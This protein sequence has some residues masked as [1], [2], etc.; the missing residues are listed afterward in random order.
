MW[1]DWI[2]SMYKLKRLSAGSGLPLRFT[3]F[4]VWYCKSYVQYWTYWYWTPT[5]GSVLVAI[6][7]MSV[8]QSLQSKPS[9]YVLCVG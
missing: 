6:T 7:D 2:Y 3:V 4:T 5:P 8:L 1:P 9:V